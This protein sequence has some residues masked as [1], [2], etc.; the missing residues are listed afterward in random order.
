MDFAIKEVARGFQAQAKRFDVISNNLANAATHGF[1]RDVFSIDSNKQETTSPDFTCGPVRHT[2]NTLDFAIDGEAFFEIRTP[3]GLRYTR[4]GSFTLN[5]EH[6]LVTQNG[7]PVMSENGR[8][9]IIEGSDVNVGPD[10][11]ISVDGEICDKLAIITFE[12]PKMLARESSTSFVPVPGTG[13]KMPGPENVT[14][15]QGYLEQSNVVVSDE[16]V[17][18]IDTMRK[19]ESFQ[20]VFQMFSDMDSKAINEVGTLR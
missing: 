4:H 17:R 8:S 13:E 12:Q 2:G 3:L 16:M 1:K 20:K 6:V 15:K 5:S 19:F 14:V 10:G 18:M 7:A 9:I 11:A